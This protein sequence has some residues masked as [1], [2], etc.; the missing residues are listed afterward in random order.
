VHN[1]GTA[2]QIILPDKRLLPDLTPPG[3]IG[4]QVTPAGIVLAVQ[5]G[6]QQI[7]VCLAPEQATQVGVGLISA[8]AVLIK[9]M[10][11][12]AQAKQPR[13]IGPAPEPEHD[14]AID[15]IVNLD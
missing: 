2:P 12:A 5:L 9:A 10:H 6:A 15:S 3:Q 14:A 4:I 8:A 1:N 7:P 11:D 13:I